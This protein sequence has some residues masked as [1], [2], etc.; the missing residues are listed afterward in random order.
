MEILIL[1]F[2]SGVIVSYFLVNLAIIFLFLFLNRIQTK[3]RQVT[4]VD[5]CILFVIGLIIFVSSYK[6]SKKGI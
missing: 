2:L 1:Y 6:E 4:F 5:M 3:P